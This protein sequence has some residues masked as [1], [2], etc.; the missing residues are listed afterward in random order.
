VK[1]KIFVQDMDYKYFVV[2]LSVEKSFDLLKEIARRLRRLGKG[3]GK[4]LFDTTLGNLNKKE[5]YIEAYFDGEKIDVS[6]FKV[7]KNPPEYYLRK[8]F[9]YL[10]RNY[11]KYVERS[12]L[13]SAEKFR[14]KNRIF[15]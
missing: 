13:T 4:V 11:S 9:E 15:I 10:S 3:E 2:M 7:V 5:R 8:S 1:F 14:Y 6:S 12:L